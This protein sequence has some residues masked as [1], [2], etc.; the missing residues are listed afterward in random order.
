MS[1]AQSGFGLIRA[2]YDAPGLDQHQRA[3]LVLL[4]FMANA[5]GNAWPSIAYMAEKTGMARRT[6]QRAAKALEAAGHI[7]RRAVPGKGT[8]Y[9]VHPRNAVGGVSQTQVS[10]GHGCQTGTG[11]PQTPT[12]VR[13]TPKLPK[14]NHSPSDAKASSGGAGGYS[15]DPAVLEWVA[16]TERAFVGLTGDSTNLDH[17]QEAL[18]MFLGREGLSATHAAW[19]RDRLAIVTDLKANGRRRPS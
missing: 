13:Q 6:V 18:S 5:K 16:H 15:S 1:A 11:A 14:N 3:V 2:A 8:A 17:W 9:N 12:R 7:T 19:A 10:E 4:A